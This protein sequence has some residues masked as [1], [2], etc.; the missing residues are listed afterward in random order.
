[1]SDLDLQRRRLVR[2]IEVGKDVE[3]D[4]LLFMYIKN[5]LFNEIAPYQL[6]CSDN[7]ETCGGNTIVIVIF[8]LKHS[9]CS[10]I[11]NDTFESV[12]VI[13]EERLKYLF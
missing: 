2:S 7:I 11:N 6:N 3:E 1:M 8:I 9:K 13:T 10:L 12:D 5:W 4:V